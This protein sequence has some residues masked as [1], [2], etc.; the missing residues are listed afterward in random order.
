MICNIIT[1]KH[2]SCSYTHALGSFGLFL[3]QLDSYYEEAVLLDL[4]SYG[5]LSHFTYS[6]MF[7]LARNSVRESCALNRF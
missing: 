4:T 1:S 2:T 5:V 3:Y 7:L 6:C